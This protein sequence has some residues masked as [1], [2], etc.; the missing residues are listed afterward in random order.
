[1]G[2]CVRFSACKLDFDQEDAKSHWKTI[3]KQPSGPRCK[4]RRLV[5]S[6]GSCP[7]DADEVT[8]SSNRSMLNLLGL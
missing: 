4:R 1:M 3:G 6:S 5:F 2:C 7:R 8:F